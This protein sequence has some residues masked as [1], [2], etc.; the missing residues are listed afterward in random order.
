MKLGAIYKKIRNR[1]VKSITFED[2]MRMDKRYLYAG[3]VPDM[4]EYKH[5]IGLSLL[6]GNDRQIKHD[7]TKALPLP[8]NS[9]DGYQSED[10]FEHIE[11]NELPAVIDEIY[12]V[13]KPGAS[14]RL[15]LPDYRCDLLHNRTLRNSEGVILFDPEGGGKYI[16]GKVIRGGHVWFPTY[17]LVKGVLDKTQFKNVIFYHYYDQD[18]QGVT[19][20]IDYSKGYVMRTPDHDN[21]VSNPYRPMSIVVDCVK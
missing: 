5:F 2:L 6:Q 19:K 14:F 11:M 10:V 4:D 18:G 8:D 21:R 1:L 9:I 3:D 20:S 12:R 17:E 7:V 15:A 13:L 16:D